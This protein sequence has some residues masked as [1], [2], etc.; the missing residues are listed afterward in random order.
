MVCVV[1]RCL[2]RAGLAGVVGEAVVFDWAGLAPPLE[3]EERWLV[4]VVVLEAVVVVELVPEAVDDWL[5]EEFEPQ[6]AS[7]SADAAIAVASSLRK[8]GHITQAHSQLGV[9]PN[10]MVPRLT[11]GQCAGTLCYLPSCACH[12]R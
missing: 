4:D 12:P 1:G 11:P 10:K 7:P 2:G 6:P 8:S 5:D 3:P 9:S